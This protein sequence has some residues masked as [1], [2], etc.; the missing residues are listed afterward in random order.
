MQPEYQPLRPFFGS[1]C[2][3]GVAA[4]LLGSSPVISVVSKTH[5]RKSR[6]DAKVP[7]LGWGPVESLDPRET[8]PTI[9][10]DGGAM[11]L[12]THA[13]NLT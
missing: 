6:G 9:C 3:N 12:L 10:R 1:F 2:L 7:Y 4:T 11:N 8:G 5:E 13:L